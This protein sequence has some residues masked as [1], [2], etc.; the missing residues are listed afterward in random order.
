MKKILL[1][2]FI[3]LVSGN[4]F[5]CMINIEQ[6]KK[7]ANEGDVESQFELGN[8][9]EFGIGVNQDYKQ[10]VYWYQKAA[11]QG[12]TIAQSSLGFCYV[13]G[14]GVATNYQQAAYWFLQAA[15]KKS[16]EAQRLL[17]LCYEG[18]LG[19][20]Q[21][22]KLAYMWYYLSLP[23]LPIGKKNSLKETMG[24]LE[25]KMTKAEIAEAERMAV[26]WLEKHK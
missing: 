16:A 7:W 9:Y 6:L 21:N 5:A 19:V 3:L 25:H 12:Y 18:A 2:V 11:E 8:A 14:L 26:E 15:E 23:N 10:A 1:C 20:P 4:A 24:E 17:G 13:N 22:N